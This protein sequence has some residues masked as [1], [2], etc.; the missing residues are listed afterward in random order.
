MAIS[1]VGTPESGGNTAANATL[2]TTAANHV[3]GNALV[4]F[5]ITGSNGTPTAGNI[6]NTAGDTWQGLTGTFV[7]DVGGNRILGWYTPS[8]NGNAADVVTIV[9]SVG[10]P[11]YRAYVLFQVNGPASNSFDSAN[12]GVS[13]PGS[14]T[15]STGTITVSGSSDIICAVGIN[16]FGTA[17]TAGSGFTSGQ[18][19]ITGDATQYYFWEYKVVSS[20]AAA[21]GTFSASP[22]WAMSGASFQAATAAGVNSGM[23][24]VM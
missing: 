19:A 9:Y 18:F 14:T 1:I 7:D 10:S 16:S 4:L 12:A 5:T 2:Q 6:S 20:S 11:V 23:L 24:L 8:T 3:A 22:P 13:I 21:D 15:P 17:F